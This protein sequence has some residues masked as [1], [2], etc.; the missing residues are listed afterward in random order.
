MAGLGPL[1]GM[2][3]G[4]EPKVSK[5]VHQLQDTAGLNKCDPS[6]L[7]PAAKYPS[8]SSSVCESKW[9]LHDT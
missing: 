3:E 7:R 9:F 4:P 5:I 2:D 6:V 1:D 8:Y